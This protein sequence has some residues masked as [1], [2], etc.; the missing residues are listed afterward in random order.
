VL[1]ITDSSLPKEEEEGAGGEVV[2][3]GG[4]SSRGGAGIDVMAVLTFGVGVSLVDSSPSELLFMKFSDIV[5]RRELTDGGEGFDSVVLC[6]RKMTFDNQLWLTP[7]PALVRGREGRGVGRGAGGVIQDIAGA[8]DVGR[9]VFGEESADA[10]IRVKWC[11]DLRYRNRGSASVSLVKDLTVRTP[12]AR[13]K[14]AQTRCTPDY[15][16]QRRSSKRIELC[17]MWLQQLLAP[18]FYA[19]PAPPNS[20]EQVLVSPLDVRVDGALALR[21]IDMAGILKLFKRESVQAAGFGGSRD[22]MLLASLGDKRDILSLKMRRAAAAARM[23]AGAGGGGGGVAGLLERG[24]QE[25][26]PREVVMITAT[27]AISNHATMSPTPDALPYMSSGGDDDTATTADDSGMPVT[28]L[29]RLSSNNKMYGGMGMGIRS[30][31]PGPLASSSADGA[32]D[33]SGGGGGGGGGGRGGEAAHKVRPNPPS[34]PNSA[35]LQKL[36]R[37][38]C[39]LRTSTSRPS[40]CA[41]PSRCRRPCSRPPP[42]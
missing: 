29:R 40:P 18:L 21:V 24:R 9:L 15:R 3:E 37:R 32:A 22:D 34:P 7:F 36:T 12:A 26:A 16:W 11:K 39:T 25:T 23:G 5:L 33:K 28:R 41:S 30:P 10:A 27:E 6:V 8:S 38:R 17:A 2:R 19:L 13:A 31:K 35:N 1:R 4:S 20:S 14:R 42:R